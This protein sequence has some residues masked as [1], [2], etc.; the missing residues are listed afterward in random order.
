MQDFNEM[1]KDKAKR[2]TGF[3]GILVALILVFSGVL[4][5]ISMKDDNL[6]QSRNKSMAQIQ[7][8][9]KNSIDMIVVGDSLSYSAISPMQLWNSYGYSS[10]VCAQSGQRIQETYSML[11]TA[12]ENQKPKLVIMET[13]PMFRVRGK[14]EEIQSSMLETCNRY[15]PIFRY[16]DVWKPLLFGKQYSEQGYNGFLIRTGKKAYGKGETYMERPLKTEKIDAGISDYMDKI[17]ALCEKN[18][19]RLVLVSVPSPRNY[20][21]GRHNTLQQYA[22]EKNLT[23]LD[24]NKSVK[25]IGI[26]WKQDCLDKGDHLN[27]SGATKVTAYLGDYLHNNTDLKDHRGETAY[28]KWNKKSKEYQRLVD[29]KIFVIR[30]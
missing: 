16:H 3:F 18:N 30:Q 7:K 24:F 23:Y 20:N 12:F 13:N 4:T 19:A 25:D 1:K 6:I 26:N 17:M 11:Q 9:K 15:F 21:N 5:D 8:Q 28:K 14:S 29:S 22:K 2:I 27:I 10:F